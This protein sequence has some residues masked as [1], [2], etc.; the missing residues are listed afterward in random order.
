MNAGAQRT[1]PQAVRLILLAG[2]TVVFATT[3]G[4]RPERDVSQAEGA[5]AAVIDAYDDEKP[6]A[7]WELC[8][9]KTQEMLTKAHQRLSELKKIVASDFP[10]G[11]KKQA[12]HGGGVSLLDGAGGP[13][14]LFAKVSRLDK[15]SFD[16]GVRYGAEVAESEI[17]TDRGIATFTTQSSQKWVLTRD[18]SGAWKTTH[19]E[20]LFKRHLEVLDANLAT[21]KAFSKASKAHEE[22]VVV[23]VKEL[24][25]GK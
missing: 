11:Q 25:R 2:L 1:Y 15:L 23:R 14:A 20:A 19:L 24:I 4:C 17:D 18:E 5:Y 9:P 12:L 8:S 22:A 10:A 21:A 7:L 16:G 6:E 3:L 13:K